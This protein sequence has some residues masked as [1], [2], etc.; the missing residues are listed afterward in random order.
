MATTILQFSYLDLTGT[1]TIDCVPN[2]SPEVLGCSP[3]AL[4]LP[5]CTAAVT[6]PGRGYRAMFGW[7]QLVKS[8]DN[9]SAGDAFEMDP[10]S[11]FAGV[12]SPY[13]FF[14]HLPTLFD[15]PSR[16][17][18]DDMDWLAHSFLAATPFD[19]KRR[20]VPLA[21]FSWGFEVRGSVVALRPVARLAPAD[22]RAHLRV[23]GQAH[24]AWRFA[25]EGWR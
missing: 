25:A 14:G 16:P 4:G 22:W 17:K 10:L 12:D 13:A 3:G 8:S 20:V 21:G 9:E 18:R 6:F 24:P 2:V 19:G 5:V 7:I 11:L 15:G 23:L 1:I